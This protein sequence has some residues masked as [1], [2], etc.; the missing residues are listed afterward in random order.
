MYAIVSAGACRVQK[1]ASDPLELELP[2]VV[3]CP[4]MVT[5]NLTLVL[6]KTK[7]MFL[8]TGP[9]PILV[10]HDGKGK[11]GSGFQTR[12]GIV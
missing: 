10:M 2:M 11:A 9:A 1:R 6:C 5:R 3:S 7:S 4:Y 8:A 12:E